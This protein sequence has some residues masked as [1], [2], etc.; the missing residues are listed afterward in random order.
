MNKKTI[1]GIE[2]G[3]GVLAGIAG[4]VA[5][6]YMLYEKTKPQQKQAAAWIVKARAEAARQ[7]KA[8]KHMSQEDYQRIMD[9]ALKHYAAMQKIGGVELMSAIKDAKMEWKHIQMQ[10]KKMAK[11]MVKPKKAVAKKKTVT[12]KGASKKKTKKA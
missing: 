7:M 1:K 8:V 3:A 5:A 2:T 6:G 10:G 11:P 9:K 12:I 4:A